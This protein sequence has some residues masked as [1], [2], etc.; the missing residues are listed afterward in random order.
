MDLRYIFRT[1]AR[2]P[3][4]TAVA[5][6]TLAL[7]IGIT[8]VVF[9]IY[10]SV[11]LRPLPVPSPQQMVRFGWRTGGFSSGQFSWSEYERLS[12]TVQSF[13]PVLASSTPQTIIFNLPDSKADAGDVVRV[14][15]VS[16][17]YF[18]A[19]GITPKIGRA[20][21]SGDPAVAMVSHDF[22]TRKLHSDPEIDGKAL[23]LKGGVLSGVFSIV[24]V[25]PGKFAGT[26]VPPQ[27]PDLWI[28]ASAQ[29]LAMPGVDWIHD[30]NAREWQVLAR[31]RPGV[32]VAQGSAELAVLGGK[33]PLEAGKP[34]HLNAVRATFFQT[35]GGAFEGFVTVCAILMVA[36]VLVLVIGCV[37]LTHLIA[38]RNSG[39][40]HET[41]LRL[42]LGAS[43]WRLM[44]QLCGESLVIG[45]LGGTVGLIL[46]IWTCNWLAVRASELIQE[47]TNGTVG[48]ALDLSPDWQVLAWT[49]TISVM[50]GIA[51]GILPALRASRGDVN[52]TLKQG[53]GAAGV[54][55]I[56]RSGNLLLT[57]QVASCLIL[58]AAAGLL[59]RGVSR[60]ADIDAGFN[61]K[62]LAV[63]GMDTRSI[64]GSPSARLKLQRQAVQRM[65]EL[66]EI[67]SVAWADRVP[68][69]GTGSGLF[70]NEKGA[71]L[72]CIFNGVSDGYFATLGIPLITGRT[73]TQQEIEREQPVALIS[74]STARRLW[75]GRDALGRRITLATNW[76]RDAAAHESL[77][78]IG[79]VKTVRS[80]YLSKEDEGYVY[81][82]RRLH[83]AGALFLVRTRTPPDKSFKSLSAALAEIQSDLPARTYMVGME[84]GP[85]RIQELMV[86]APAVSAS[87]LGG[88]ALMLACLGIYGVVSHLVSQRTR[89]IGIRISLGAERWDVISVV[90]GQTLR[91]VAWG[92]VAGLLGAFCVS[93][94]LQALIVMPDAPDL[95]YG[96]GAFDPVAFLGVLSV[97]GAVVVIAAFMPMR[98]AML[99]EAAV[100]LR[101]E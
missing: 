59:F 24:G 51:V 70:R 90:G 23:R 6:A 21:A 14:R 99:V 47:I 74:E 81:I 37:N 75:P 42:A 41:A 80:T 35:D 58:L 71:V 19:L 28:P 97:L 50:T 53:R 9:T 100:A 45:L 52:S 3:G 88:L 57:I 8:T 27:S 79:V 11:A 2:T 98:R 4:F 17:N 96:A 83:D 31:R 15:F 63:V 22:W 34:V 56:R 10:G 30:N 73:F 33:W 61:L 64:A 29:I 91:P 66:P 82:P 12:K 40:E 54:I 26:G 93:G 85:V 49:A 76:L 78:V 60:S 95:T 94:L 48:V 87:V 16:A 101:H 32:T 5:V 18:D 84:Q 62:N 44:R 1:L 43:R 36:V 86:R 25:A 38:A 13:S 89:E 69:L 92:A 72:P 77:T 39:R 65:Q 55:S 67:A 46:S 68:F 7:G 20:F